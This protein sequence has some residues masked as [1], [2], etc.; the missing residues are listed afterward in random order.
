M[1]NVAL[2][3]FSDRLTRRIVGEIARVV[4][5]GGLLLL[6]VN[7]TQD[8]PYRA[9]YRERV[10]EVEPCYYL[11]AHGQT[12]RFFSEAYLRDVLEAWELLELTHV[13]LQDRAGQTFKCVWRCVARRANAAPQGPTLCPQRGVR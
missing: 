8:M 5:P 10:C 4:K 9:A 2:H 1:S 11:E 6:H 13:P 12:M 3:S 7:S